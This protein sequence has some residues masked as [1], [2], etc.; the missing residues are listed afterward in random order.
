MKPFLW[1]ETFKSYEKC[2]D[3]KWVECYFNYEDWEDLFPI[4]ISKQG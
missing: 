1:K 2:E 3:Y 4:T